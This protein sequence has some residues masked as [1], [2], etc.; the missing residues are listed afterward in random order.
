M[1]LG[2]SSL[3]DGVQVFDFK[4]MRNRQHFISKGRGRN[5]PL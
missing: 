1:L 2:S 3:D 4:S 5:S